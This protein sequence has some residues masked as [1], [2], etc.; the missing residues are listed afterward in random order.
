MLRMVPG[1]FIA[2]HAGG[3]KAEQIFLRGFDVDH[4]TDVNLEVDGLP[5]NMVSHAHGQ[6]YSDLHFVIPEIVNYVDFNKGPYY[7]DKGDFTTAG[8]VDFQTKHVLENNFASL[9]GGRFGTR[10][11]VAGV[12]LTTTKQSRTHAFVASELSYTD[13]YVESPQH[14]SRVN[15]H[16]KISHRYNEHNTLSFGAT[17]FR[18]RWN[19]SGQIPSRAVASGQITRF[20]SIDDSE[21]GKTSRAN[22]YVRHLHEYPT[23]ALLAQQLYVIAYDFNLF[24][25]F[26]FYL[27]DPDHGDQI[28]Q[29]EQRWIYG[30]KATYN[31]VGH[32]WG[33][34]LATEAGAGF[35]MDDVRDVAL[36]HTTKRQW[37]SD[38]RRGRVFE[39]NA[40]AFVRE[41]LS[42]TEQFSVNAAVRLDHFQFH[43]TASVQHGG[44]TVTKSIVS[45]K[46]NMNYQLNP[47]TQ[48]YL[49]T[50][51]GFH[52]NDARVAV[53]RSGRDILP[54][55]YGVDV[56]VYTKV[57]DKLL[58]NVA[59][60][61]LDL[62]QEFVYVGD[63]GIVEPSGRTQRQGI[64]LS[65]RYQLNP[66][67]FA[68]VDV[69]VTK[70]RSKDNNEHFI[71][72]APRFT[73]IGGLS[74]QFA[75]GF[76]GSLRYRHLSDRPANEDHSITAPGYFLTDATVNFTRPKFGIALS[77]ENIFNSSWNE[78]QFATTSRLENEV[79]AATE[80]HFTPGTPVFIKAKISF[81]F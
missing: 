73:T 45:P 40:F 59:L 65:L 2:Q 34:K 43:Y 31:T 18:S 12:N 69:N 55:A 21:G 68:D 62:A 8:Y 35:R 56:G 78:A 64:D 33:K 52:S 39:S 9:E 74:F 81:F 20:G 75:S 76:H 17:F 58:L 57:A 7:A 61:R 54:R 38:D 10:R 1:L 32:W 49:S 41:T 24:S 25:N 13:G 29:Q 47:R 63:E 27:N 48:L 19:A 53:A 15:V 44:G 42:I 22:L 14:F 23:G 67:L 11:A 16:S 77:A 60:W 30:Y 70:P 71:P 37:L 26:T 51:L 79:D 66:W 46:L 36:S 4:G 72:L 50:G 28:Q 3:G 80:I 5:V 6:G